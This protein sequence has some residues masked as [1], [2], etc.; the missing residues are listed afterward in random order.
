MDL[1][2][3]TTKKVDKRLETIVPAFKPKA[4][5]FVCGFGQTRQSWAEALRLWRKKLKGAVFDGDLYV[6][7]G[8]GEDILESRDETFCN[9]PHNY[10]SGDAEIYDFE[11]ETLAHALSDF[12]LKWLTHYDTI[13]IVAHSFG[14]RLA[15]YIINSFPEEWF[16]T[17]TIRGIALAGTVTAVGNGVGVPEENWGRTLD[18]LSVATMEQFYLNLFNT[19]DSY[20]N[21]RGAPGSMYSARKRQSPFRTQTEFKE[22]LIACTLINLGAEYADLATDV[23]YNSARSYLFYRPSAVMRDMTGWS[24]ASQKEQRMMLLSAELCFPRVAPLGDLGRSRFDQY[25]KLHYAYS[26]DLICPA[27]AVQAD[28]TKAGVVGSEVRELKSPH[29]NVAQICELLL[30]PQHPDWEHVGALIAAAS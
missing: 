11:E 26:D 28:L 7:A 8:F 21:L 3:V 29:L 18:G 10:Y 5:I 16:Q 12:Y 30:E 4:R 27:A 14:V 9:Y 1:A 2:Y 6:A 19:P 17:K 20:F 25:F 13:E 15:A 22:R 24:Y 23:C